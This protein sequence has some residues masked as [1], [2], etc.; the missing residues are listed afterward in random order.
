ML[1]PVT[2]ASQLAATQANPIRT[3][4]E[5]GAPAPPDAAT[6]TPRVGRPPGPWGEMLGCAG[7]STTGDA[8]APL[9]RACRTVSPGAVTKDF[10]EI[11][12][13]P[14]DAAGPMGARSP[15]TDRS[16]LASAAC[17]AEHRA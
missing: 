9:C 10:G 8:P 6:P 12:L 14:E 16:G 3:I 7:A 11:R 5:L 2:P 4:R 1:S 15:V 13:P 17:V